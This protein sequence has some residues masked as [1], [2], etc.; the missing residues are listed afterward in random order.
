MSQDAISLLQAE[1]QQMRELLQQLN[2]AITAESPDGAT[3]LELASRFEAVLSLH[4]KRE[5]EVLF[6]PIKGMGPVQ[7]VLQEHERLHPLRAKLAEALAAYRADAS[8]DNLKALAYD[9]QQVA[10]CMAGHFMKEE[11]LCFRIAQAMLGAEKLVEM[12]TAM[13]DIR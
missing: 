10:Y 8:E 3:V 6:P 2:A 9:A 13:A 11:Q 12:G 4:E 5:E 7:L 1:H